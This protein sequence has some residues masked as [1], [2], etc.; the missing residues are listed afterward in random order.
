MKIDQKGHTVCIKD[1]QG[2][3]LSYLSKVTHEYK[4]FEKFNIIIDLRMYKNLSLAMVNDFLGLS[5][6]HKKSKKSFIIVIYD[7]DI[8]A[9][10]T[11]LAVVRTLQEA[12]DII[13]MEEIERDLGF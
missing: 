8:N 11:K 3:I 6:I 12:H 9:V 2:D 7:L 10:S 5:Q 13:D 4:S 1:T